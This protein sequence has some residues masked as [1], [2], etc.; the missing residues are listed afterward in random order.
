MNIDKIKRKLISGA[1][2][3]FFGAF[4]GAGLFLQAMTFGAIIGAG[5]G[6]G[7]GLILGGMD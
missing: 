3:G 1:I 7:L 6:A 4:V 2:C 5:C